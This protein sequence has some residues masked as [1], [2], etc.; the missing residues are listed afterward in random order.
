M[1]E[2]DFSPD[3]YGCI[4]LHSFSLIAVLKSLQLSRWTFA[5]DDVK[6]HAR[7]YY[8]WGEETQRKIHFVITKDLEAHATVCSFNQC[9]HSVDHYCYYVITGSQKG[10]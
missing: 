4:Q 5:V 10:V 7:I 6:Y 2:G 9:F 3:A 1:E 8:L